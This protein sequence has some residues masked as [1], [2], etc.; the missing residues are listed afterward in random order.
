[1]FCACEIWRKDLFAKR[2]V[3]T[4]PTTG[5]ETS[6]EGAPTSAGAAARGGGAPRI[7]NDQP[8]CRRPLRSRRARRRHQGIGGPRTARPRARR[9]HRI[10]QATARAEGPY[11]EPGG[12]GAAQASRDGANRAASGVHPH[13]IEAAHPAGRSRP[14]LACS[15]TSRRRITICWPIGRTSFAPK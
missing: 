4:V 15:R 10:L 9:I 11:A 12:S 8:H 1:M 5:A 14:P 7:K 13:R 6:G 2:E 3:V